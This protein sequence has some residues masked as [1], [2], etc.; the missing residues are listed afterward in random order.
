MISPYAAID[1][2]QTRND[3]LSARGEAAGD[4]AGRATLMADL[5]LFFTVAANAIGAVVLGAELSPPPLFAADQPPASPTA[6]PMPATIDGSSMSRPICGG[7]AS[8][9]T[10]RSAGSRRTLTLTSSTY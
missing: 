7:R 1:G 5:H 3:D 2:K 9:A 6:M 4:G 8:T 10:S